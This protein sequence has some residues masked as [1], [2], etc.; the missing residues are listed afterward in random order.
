MLRFFKL[1]LAFLIAVIFIG[2]AVANRAVITLT[3]FPLP[4]DVKLP[5]FLLALLCFALGAAAGRLLLGL[6]PFRALRLLKL[7]R[8][9]NEA[10]EHELALLRQKKQLPVA[11]AKQ[12]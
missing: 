3:L 12:P 11:P 9:R 10:L 1:L 5:Q 2:F 6:S 8:Q 7:E 4:Y